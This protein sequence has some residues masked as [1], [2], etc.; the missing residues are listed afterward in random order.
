MATV[1][2]SQFTQLNFTVYPNLQSKINALL[3]G[4]ILF[5]KNFE[6]NEGADVLIQ[7]V[8]KKFQ[9][10][11]ISYDIHA[12]EDNP[13]YW[14]T[15]NVGINDLS[16]FTVFK[17]E[18]DIFELNNKYTIND[19]VNYTTEEGTSDTAII[20]AVYQSN[21]D[22]GVFAYKLSQEQNL[23]LEDDLSQHLYQ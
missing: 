18:E 14:T 9:V 5:I 1:D 16:L 21:N 12:D 10:T 20:E 3:N 8:Q 22:P 2:P 15:F 17:F 13:R 7:L 23:Y 19:T 6:S 11:Q 4:E